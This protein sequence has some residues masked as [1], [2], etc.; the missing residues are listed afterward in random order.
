MINLEKIILGNFR[1]IVDYKPSIING[2]DYEIYYYESI[3]K[4]KCYYI[5]CPDSYLPLLKV[6]SIRF[7]DEHFKNTLKIRLDNIDN[8]LS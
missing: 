2:R 3:G 6:N 1:C 5:N 4:T 8:I 7:I